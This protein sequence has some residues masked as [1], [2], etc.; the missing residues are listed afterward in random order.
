MVKD[1]M[2][3]FEL[4]LVCPA[5]ESKERAQ[6]AEKLKESDK[7]LLAKIDGDADAAMF[8]NVFGNQKQAGACVFYDAA[9]ISL[10]YSKIAHGNQSNQKARTLFEVDVLTPHFPDYYRNPQKRA[11]SDDQSPV[12]VTFL[13]VA[14]GVRF[15]F[16]VGMAGYCREEN[17]AATQAAAWLKEGLT[18]YGIGGKTSS[19]YGVFSETKAQ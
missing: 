10:P 8:Q 16:S 17:T 1:S 6:L 15:G 14:A 11:P 9:L 5:S 2:E 12:P 3:A 19:G 18:V 13:T 4:L 7:T